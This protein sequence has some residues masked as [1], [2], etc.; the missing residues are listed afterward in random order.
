MAESIWSDVPPAEPGWHWVR[1]RG[2]QGE[3]AAYFDGDEREGWQVMW[4]V[5]S[6]KTARRLLE[7]GPRIPS[8]EELMA[9]RRARYDHLTIPDDSS[10]L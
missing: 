3:F 4:D 5:M 6:E 7:F 8:A 2:S 9:L 10:E 1:F